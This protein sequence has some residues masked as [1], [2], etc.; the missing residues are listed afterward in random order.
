MT[1]ILSQKG[2]FL[3]A[4]P[5]DH[6]YHTDRFPGQL[7][8]HKTAEGRD[9]PCLDRATCHQNKAGNR[10]LHRK[11]KRIWMTWWPSDFPSPRASL[12]KALLYLPNPWSK[13]LF[14]FAPERYTSLHKL[15]IR[16]HQECCPSCGHHSE[17][18]TDTW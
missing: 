8:R 2:I 16:D 6:P 11:L 15:L 7:A 3:S 18:N 5:L 14:G 4:I 13:K 12:V 1:Q 17:P 9:G 10:K